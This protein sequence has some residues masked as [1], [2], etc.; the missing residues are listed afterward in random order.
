MVAGK[1]VSSSHLYDT[2]LNTPIIS[3]TRHGGR[4]AH[5]HLEITLHGARVQFPD[6]LGG[7]VM[8]SV[9]VIAMQ[10]S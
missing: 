3:L 5:A 4:A 2:Y 8:L 9:A 1:L 7:V 10:L 6:K